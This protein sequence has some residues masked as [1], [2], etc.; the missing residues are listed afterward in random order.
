MKRAD[1]QRWQAAGT[2]ADLGALTAQW[3]EGTLASQPGYAA[4][5]GPDPETTD[6]IPTLAAVNRAGVLTAGSQPGSDGPGFDGA[7]WRQRAAV[8]GIADD[9]MRRLLERAVAGTGLVMVTHTAN[10][11]GPVDGIVVTERAGLPYTS[12]GTH[13]G[14]RDLAWQYEECN[15]AAVAVIQRANQITL[16]DPVWGRNDVLWPLLDDVTA[17]HSLTSILSRNTSRNAG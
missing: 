6:L 1:R 2:L 16:I 10:R 13:L 4:N 12:F 17:K 9:D 8:E 15:P 14:S 7:H 11:K 3:L 5:C